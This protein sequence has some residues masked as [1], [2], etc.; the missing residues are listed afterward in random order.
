[1]NFSVLTFQA[2]DTGR[3]SYLADFSTGFYPGPDHQ[4]RLFLTSA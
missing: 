2:L 1:M 4:C 3:L